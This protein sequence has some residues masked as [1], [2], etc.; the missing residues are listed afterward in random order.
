MKK[1]EMIVVKE[2]YDELRVARDFY[3][4]EMNNT[5]IC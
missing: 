4:N 5:S 3:L 1:S 2:M